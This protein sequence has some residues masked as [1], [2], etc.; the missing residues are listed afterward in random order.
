[1][2]KRSVE[3]RRVVPGARTSLPIW[4]LSPPRVDLRARH[5]TIVEIGAAAAAIAADWRAQAATFLPEERLSVLT[6]E[7]ADDPFLDRLREHLAQAEV[8]WRLL[9]VGEEAEVLAVQREA[10]HAGAIAAEIAVFVTGTP[11]RRI[12]CAHC[13]TVHR[14]E[15]SPGETYRCAGCGYLLLIHPHLSRVHGAYLGAR[16]DAEV[17]P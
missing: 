2:E 11:S 14:E 12:R 17:A 15:L 4:P 3:N 8:G 16:A 6:A 13:H 10:I 1:M 7:M 9:I 5:L